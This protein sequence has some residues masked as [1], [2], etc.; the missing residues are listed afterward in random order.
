MAFRF[1][2][3]EIPDLILIEPQRFHDRRGYFMEAYKRSAFAAQGISVTFVQDNC[4]HSLR[5]V[6]RGLHY[7]K[8]PRAQGKLIMVLSGEIFDVAVDIRRGSPTYGRPVSVVLSSEN[9]R[10]LYIPPGFAHGYCVLSESA[11]VFYKV[12]EEYAPELDRGIRWNDPQIGIHWPIDDPILSPKD[13][14][15]PLLDQADHDFV[16]EP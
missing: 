10:M 13:A 3:L 12:T 7:Q 2:R 11:D 6:L 1:Q 9:G 4:A 16:Y 8:R 5:G 14:Q 15:L